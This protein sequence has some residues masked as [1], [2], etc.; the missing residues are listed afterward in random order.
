MLCVRTY[1]SKDVVAIPVGEGAMSV[2]APDI[3]V[4]AEP[5]RFSR[6]VVWKMFV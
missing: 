4:N 2:T 3:P 6:R 1:L 5:S